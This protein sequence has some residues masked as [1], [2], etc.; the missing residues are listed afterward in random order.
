M[1]TGHPQQGLI[2]QFP[3]DQVADALMGAT[4]IQLRCKAFPSDLC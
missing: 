2:N 1:C 4:A 3:S